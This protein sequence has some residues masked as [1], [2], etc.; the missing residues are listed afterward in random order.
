MA[1][2][3][4][5]GHDS[6]QRMPAA[7]AATACRPAVLRLDLSAFRNHADT[8][9]RVDAAPVVLSGP[10]GA[11]KTNVIEALSFLAPGRGLRRCRLSEADGRDGGRA[12]AVSAELDGSQGRVRIG[13]GRDPEREGAG[14]GQGE[15]RLIRLDGVPAR[16]QQALADHLAVVW[17]TPEHDRLF[18]DAASTRRRFLDR[19]VGAY[20]PEHVGRV[21][22]YEHALRERA[23][24]LAAPRPDPRW[25]DVLEE[26]LA[27]AGIAIC[28]ARHHLIA[29]L[30]AVLA[31]AA[32]PFL[33]PRLA[34]SGTLEAWLE[35]APALVVED[36]LRGALAAGRPEDAAHGGAGVG[37][38]R[39]DLVA[40]HPRSGEEAK[41][42]ST[43]EQKAMV[44]ATVLAHARLIA[45]DH[46]LP[47]LL[48]LDEVAAHLDARRR[49]ALF[50]ELTGLG[51]QAWL[52]GADRDLFTALAGRATFLSVRDGR[53][54]AA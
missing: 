31:D 43:G 35:D 26:R 46:G 33:A 5:A 1:Q 30:S 27:A 52:T 38:H 22:A 41:A 13:T 17:L 2:A 40:H 21:S 53:V 34:L 18:A 24:L 39:S 51:A 14:E 44:I 8:H 7:V 4:P 25:L 6:Q 32:G 19:L 12:W 45:A 11:G 29:R 9:I 42:C 15:R 50:D 23:R 49:A 47:P 36:R 37:P 10:N 3:A 28:H 16:S 20:D 48:L 54:S